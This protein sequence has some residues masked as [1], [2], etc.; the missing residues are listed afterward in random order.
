MM[1]KTSL[2]K[3]FTLIELVVVIIILGI[4]A[5]VAAPK[6]INL[7]SE[8][9]S[10]AIEQIKASSQTANQFAYAKSQIP[11][12]AIK[13]HAYRN[14][15]VDID[16][17]GDGSF[18]TRLLSGYVDNTHIDKLLELDDIFIIE[19]QGVN[20]TYIGYDDDDDNKVS[21]DL[22]YFRY[23]QATANSSPVYL[24]VNDGC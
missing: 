6:F 17:D 16:L 23:Q 8:A 1:I 21:D 5:S 11:G 2:T 4:L 15:I 3:G 22:C 24:T 13:P 18:E 7:S 10:E 19:E 12:T 9:R 20:F 14:D